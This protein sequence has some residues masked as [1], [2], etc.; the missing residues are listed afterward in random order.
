MIWDRFKKV[1]RLDAEDDDSREVHL[2]REK[3]TGELRVVRIMHNDER[4]GDYELL[5]SLDHPQIQRT[6]E[7]GPLD[8][9]GSKYAVTDYVKG[10]DLY[11]LVKDGKLDTNAALRL[12][13]SSFGP[14]EY[15]HERGL[16]HGDL[17][18]HNIVRAGDIAVLIDLE[19]VKPTS[20][21]DVGMWFNPNY[22]APEQKGLLYADVD[23]RSDLFNIGRGIFNSVVGNELFKR[24]IWRIS[25]TGDSSIESFVEDRGLVADGQFPAEL[26]PVLQKATK[27][28]PK[29]RYQT[30]AELRTDLQVVYDSL[31]GKN[32]RK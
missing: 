14:T 30:V 26:V 19:T 4:K 28:D 2:A 10:T 27:Y 29:Q 16:V 13:I 8:K 9:N 3:A 1:R 21:D 11:S 25:D 6:L 20:A 22:G 24:F 23:N 18:P 15:L 32:R 5:T 17:K 31:S 7:W 12:Y